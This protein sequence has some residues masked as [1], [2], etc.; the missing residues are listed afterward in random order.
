MVSDNLLRDTKPCYYL[1]K[2]ENIHGFTIIAKHW[3]S[4]NPLREVFYYYDDVMMPLG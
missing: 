2:D 4:F 1:I 3:H